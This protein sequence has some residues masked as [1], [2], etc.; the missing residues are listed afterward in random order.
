MPMPNSPP[1]FV[2]QH[3]TRPSVVI[4]QPKPQPTQRRASVGRK[5]ERWTPV[6]G[7]SSTAISKGRVVLLLEV[8]VV[9]F[10][11][12]LASCTG[13]LVVHPAARSTSKTVP[14]KRMFTR[15][16]RVCRAERSGDMA[17]L[18]R[19]RACMSSMN[20]TR[21][22]ET[23]RETCRLFGESTRLAR[24]GYFVSCAC[25]GDLSEFAAPQTRPLGGLNPSALP[26]REEIRHSPSNAPSHLVESCQQVVNEN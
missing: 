18:Y 6:G 8:E 23:S 10:V 14:E 9:E 2:P 16:R 21:Y 1:R 12:L 25:P 20:S 13:V 3:R 24:F 17:V 7:A 5:L 26:L 15:G 11:P 19:K 4:P 22:C